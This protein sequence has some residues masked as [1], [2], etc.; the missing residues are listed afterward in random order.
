MASNGNLEENILTQIQQSN[1]ACSA[2]EISKA[3]GLSTAKQV[4]PTLYSLEK[5]GIIS[6]VQEGRKVCWEMS[7]SNHAMGTVQQGKGGNE[8]EPFDLHMSGSEGNPNSDY[9]SIENMPA[10]KHVKLNRKGSEP[11][12][13]EFQDEEMEVDV[14][15]IQEA[16]LKPHSQPEPLLGKRPLLHRDPDDFGSQ[17][18]HRPPQSSQGAS[19]R[20]KAPHELRS[21][22]MQQPYVEP[23]QEAEHK[24]HF[25]SESLHGKRPL[26][27]SGPDDFRSQE[28]H[29]P[30]QSS[31][32]KAPHE[33]RGDEMQSFAEP[34]Q[35]AEHKPHFQ[36]EHLLGKR[37]FQHRDSHDFRSHQA[38]K[39]PQPSHEPS[40][41]PKAPHEMMQKLGPRPAL[42]VK[43]MYDRPQATHPERQYGRQSDQY[44]NRQGYYDEEPRASQHPASFSGGYEEEE[45]PNR[46]SSDQRSGSYHQS[47]Q[48]YYDEGPRASQ[49]PASFSGGYE[50]E[51]EP[52]RWSS[53]QRSGS[54]DQRDNYQTSPP[55]LMDFSFRER[56]GDQYEVDERMADKIVTFLKQYRRPVS[57]LEVAR[58]V[59]KKTKKEVNPTLYEM[60]RQGMIIKTSN[61]PPAWKLAPDGPSAFVAP[62]DQNT[63]SASSGIRSQPQRTS[64]GRNEHSS[65][66]QRE[67]QAMARQ[68]SW[69][70]QTSEESSFVPKSSP[71]SASVHS[72]RQQLINASQQP[73][74]A[75][76]GQMSR[77]NPPTPRQ[78]IPPTPRQQIPAA[79]RQQMPT[80]LSS[81]T[82]A[83]LNKNPV[84]AINE[85]AQKNGMPITFDLLYE[86][87][88]G[89]NKFLVAVNMN[90]KMYNAVSAGNMKDA[91]REA[92][93]V[94]L[95]E[96][97][98]QQSST[99]LATSTRLGSNATLSHFD[100]IASLSHH[101]F[102]KLSSEVQEKF[103]GRKVI[104]AIIMKTYEDE[105]GICVSVGAG[106]RCITGDRLTL[107]GK[108]VNDSH[109]EIICR[110]AF[111]VFLYS[112]L[113]KYYSQE[114]S[115]FEEGGMDGKLQVK[116]GFTF[117]LYISTAPCGDGALFSPREMN[118]EAASGPRDHSPLYTSKQQGLLRTK[119]EDGEG[120]IPIDPNDGPQTWD[121][122]V[123]GK[124]LRTM[125]CTDKVCRWNVL[126]MQGA[127]LSH[128]IDPIYLESLTLGYLYEHGHLSRAVCCRLSKNSDIDAEL[129]M[130]YALNHPWLGR[131]TAYDPPRE[132]EKTNNLSINWYLR[133]SGVEMTDGR[134]G[135]CLTRTDNA[136]TPSRL[137]K[138]ALYKH[139]KSICSKVPELLH[140]ANFETY[141]EAKENAEGFQKAK[142]IMNKQF[143]TSK[144]GSWVKKPR[145]LELFD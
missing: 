69:H 41:R 137:C 65:Q 118:T 17:Q 108:T 22:V 77:P 125:S 71:A 28:A 107:D 109:A 45:E 55:P 138:A 75:S 104:A 133:G 143:K 30:Q 127:L 119:I 130:P 51:E 52:N 26:L 131:V 3:I 1:A 33:F 67:S 106:N 2:L 97:L 86:G 48:G 70:S 35:E 144:Y 32:P 129:P 50:E 34:I 4:N 123:M 135:S 80:E 68:L 96:I 10:R 93:D 49:H 24:P 120:T 54:Y 43:A 99:A 82:F 42:L 63:A 134:T 39:T 102:I 112:E 23:I 66:P 11:T 94:A 140:L 73:R 72:E 74:G 88:G 116:D 121:G 59:N 126:G 64:W 89:Q 79:P 110:R 40:S 46:W 15:P 56:Q 14:E 9:E 78:Q 19:S 98:S 85:Y 83:A 90:G 136:P 37:P 111:L 84:S 47:R 58:A 132:T 128:L 142:E 114:K 60:Q 62:S 36:S 18:A 53:D 21:D 6:K 124:R 44:Q 115:I 38:H 16:E 91:R 87:K 95:R 103:A 8:E 113:D 31:R 61:Q 105:T 12:E 5:K 76:Y 13:S 141:R 122:I 20:P 139:F 7:P 81:V 57:T 27:H 117:H 25:Q 145:E 92:A 100:K 101:T 29:R